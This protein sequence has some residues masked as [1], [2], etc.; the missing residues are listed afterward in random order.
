MKNIWNERY[1]GETF[2]YGDAPNDFLVQVANNLTP[3]S[4]ILCLAEGEGRNAVYLSTLGHD[5]TAIDQSEV[6]LEKLQLLAMQKNVH[7]NTIAA[8]LSDYKIEDKKWDAIISI[9]CHLPSKLRKQVHAQC[10]SGLKDSGQIILEAYTPKQLE[11]KTG[12]P[13]D[14]DLLMNESALREEFAGLN[15]I[16]LKEITREIKEGQGHSGMSAVV[17]LLAIKLRK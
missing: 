9:W 5:V 7:I 2:Y 11:Y 10:V 4:K 15:F 8:D 6:G 3:K 12:G 1:K 16:I 13:T 17:Q 14:T